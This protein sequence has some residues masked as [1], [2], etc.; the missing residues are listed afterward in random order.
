MG[1]SDLSLHSLI[2]P[3]TVSGCLL[4]LQAE[5]DSELKAH[6]S[7]GATHSS[8]GIWFDFIVPN[9]PAFTQQVFVMFGLILV[10]SFYKTSL[11]LETPFGYLFRYVCYMVIL[12]RLMQGDLLQLILSSRTLETSGLF[13]API[14]GSESLSLCHRAVQ[15]ILGTYCVG[16]MVNV[17]WEKG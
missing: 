4:N 14:V 9:I 6:S 13:Q 1:I 15:S 12:A 10:C 7:Y 5:I 17:L 11:Y 3:L 8:T 2:V 16:N